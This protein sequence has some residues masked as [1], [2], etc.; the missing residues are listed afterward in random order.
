MFDVYGFP[1]DPTWRLWATI[2]PF[3]W[4]AWSVWAFY[5]A[6]TGS[7]SESHL[8]RAR[9]TLFFTAYPMVIQCRWPVIIG[10]TLACALSLWSWGIFFRVGSTQSFK[11]TTDELR[12]S[13][14]ALVLMGGGAKGAYEVGVWKALWERGL[15][16]FVTIS[17][18]S[19]G[20]LNAYLIANL[21]PETVED[22]WRRVVSSD[23]LQRRRCHWWRVFKLVLGEFLIVSP[24]LITIAGTWALHGAPP[25]RVA[26]ALVVLGNGLIIQYTAMKIAAKRG[27]FIPLLTST[28]E[29]G[30]TLGRLLLF[31]GAAAGIAAKVSSAELLGLLPLGVAAAFL[32]IALV[33]AGI[34]ILSRTFHDGLY[35]RG[36]L[37]NE[38]EALSNHTSFVHSDG[39]VWAT[40]AEQ[41]RYVSPFEVPLSAPW[42]SSE[43]L[44]VARWTPHYLDLRKST[45]ALT[46]R[47]TSAVPFVFRSENVDGR[48]VSDGG[49]C[50]NWPVTPA[51][52]AHPDYIIAVGVNR[53]DWI[54][55]NF[56]LRWAVERLW[57]QHYFAH[58]QVQEVDEIRQKLQGGNTADYWD[59]LPGAPPIRKFPKIIWVSP[60][61]EWG[62][63]FGVSRLGDIFG[64]LRFSERYREKLVAEGYRNTIDMLDLL[65]K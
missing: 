50:D 65:S 3:P 58:A 18:T 30:V 42:P 2:F 27:T 4:A 52:L 20:A 34:G 59:V 62:L 37:N 21:E 14:V 10:V 24:W 12:E 46:L 35:P 15:R 33:W 63:V 55:P 11:V 13:R 8:A 57:P 25:N 29:D 16:S 53:G 47:A 45:I 56:A 36:P 9:F 41:V 43:D 23:V 31:S 6:R 19:V 64:T 5:H 39:P 38:I 22:V 44:P 7:L 48:I 61:W 17:G 51:L 1:L 40:I 54:A 49:L 26:T 60:A 32:D 28:P